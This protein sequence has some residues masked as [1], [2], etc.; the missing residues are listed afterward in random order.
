MSGTSRGRKPNLDDNGAPVMNYY[1]A[2]R[3]STSNFANIDKSTLVTMPNEK[4]FIDCHPVIR[5]E[6][7]RAVKNLANISGFRAILPFA[8]RNNRYYASSSFACCMGGMSTE[9][10]TSSG[11]PFKMTYVKHPQEGFYKIST[12]EADT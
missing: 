7:V 1:H 8:D 9:R 6:L 12:A 10:K 5:E 2:L 4:E 11:C 3:M